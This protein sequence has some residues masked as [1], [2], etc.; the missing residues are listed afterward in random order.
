M[1]KSA[2]LL[3]L[4]LQAFLLITTFTSSHA[5]AL[6]R[7]DQPPTPADLVDLNALERE[8]IEQ[9]RKKMR[10]SGCWWRI[11]GCSSLLKPDPKEVPNT[12]NPRLLVALAKNTD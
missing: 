8:K 9:G 1:D 12:P 11:G 2:L 10:F 5:V 3:L 6:V 4:S 7:D